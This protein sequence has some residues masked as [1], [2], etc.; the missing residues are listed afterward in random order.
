MSSQK[1]RQQNSRDTDKNAGQNIR[2][3]LFDLDDTL[4]AVAPVIE[5]AE[6]QLQQWMKERVP[7][8][9]ARYSIADLR[10]LRD[11]LSLQDPRY[12][13]D[14]WALRLQL[15]KNLMHEAEMETELAT[16]L[17]HEAMAVFAH[18]RNQVLFYED[19]MPGLQALQTLP[20]GLKLGCISNGFADIRAIGLHTHFHVNLAAHQFGCAKPD[21]RIFLE[22]AQQLNLSTEQI[23]YV[24]DHLHFDVKGAQAVGMQGVWINRHGAA[25]ENSTI[26]PDL[27]IRDLSEIVHY[28]DCK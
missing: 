21:P 26:E 20:Q 13:F 10:T 4:W 19:V 3:V 11:Q 16:N 12:S 7:H 14:L 5:H 15:L 28:L 17:A 9:P 8:I 27:I 22:A 6:H 2:A 23:M 24:G 18:A 25:L 1:N